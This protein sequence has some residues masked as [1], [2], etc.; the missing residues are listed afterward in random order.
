MARFL[1]AVSQSRTAS[2]ARSGPGDSASGARWTSA[3]MCST[4]RQDAV[5]L[6]LASKL[7][8]DRSVVAKA[9]TGERPPTPDVLAAW[10]TACQLDEDLFGRFANLA[11][12]A[13]G[14]IPAWFETWLEAEREAHMLRIW[15]PLIIPGLL[16]TAMSW[17][18]WS[19]P[20]TGRTQG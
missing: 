6:A 19:R 7:G 18:R 12:S 11:R 3:A 9:E 15:Q 1:Q 16:Q 8:F 14:P 4:R 10:C 13:D 20:P 5:H 2:S 17:F